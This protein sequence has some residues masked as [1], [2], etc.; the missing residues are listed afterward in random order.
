MREGDLT[1][2]RSAL[3]CTEQ[4]AEFARQLDLG[5]A[6][7]LGRGESEAGGRQ[8]TALLCAAFEALVGALYL[9]GGLEAVQH[10][11]EPLLAPA[12]E[13]VLISNSDRDPKSVLQERVQALGFPP[14]TYHTLRASGP[15][16]MKSFEVEVRIAGVPWGKGVG[17]SKHAATKAAARAALERLDQTP[18]EEWAATASARWND[19]QTPSAA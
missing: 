8:R 13:R 6:L 10:F 17:S 16:H 4:L 2:L 3:V 5:R 12:A 1:R 9:D 7:R 15:E 11:L 18:L 19:P 14:P